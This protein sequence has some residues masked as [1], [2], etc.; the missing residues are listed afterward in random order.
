[1]K[2]NNFSFKK[3]VADNN[4]SCNQEI[5]K[6]IHSNPL[7]LSI[8][9][10]ARIA[11]IANSLQEDTAAYYTDPKTVDILCENLPTIKVSYLRI[12]EPSVGV[13]NILRQ[14]ITYYKD[15]VDIIE[16]DVFDINEH[17][18]EICKILIEKEFSDLTKI[19]INY[20]HADFLVYTFSKQYDL[21]VGNPPFIKIKGEYRQKLRKKFDNLVADNMSAF[22]LDK[23][24]ELSKNVVLIMPKYF[25]H[26]TDFAI[27]REKLKKIS[28]ECIV[29]FGESGFKGV[30][31]ETICLF[32]N[33]TLINTS[34]TKVISVPKHLKLL[35]IQSEITQ[36]SFP[37][38]LLYINKNFIDLASQLEFG[39]FKVF[40]DR[41]ITSKMLSS[42]SDIWV[43]R[44]KNIPRIGG[45]ANHTDNDVF[46][47][48]DQLLKLS[49]FKYLDRTDVFLSPNMTYYPRVIKK[50]KN[51]VV[52]GSIAIFELKNNKT[53]STEDLL[54]FSSQEF[55]DFYRVARNYS[56][57][58]LNIDNIAI[59]YFGKK[60]SICSTKKN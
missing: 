28:I 54:F 43:I 4:L 21:V 50:P 10:L 52:N 35:Q 44:S 5:K 22:F 12:L 27:S 3:I 59:F 18:L 13:G 38:W 1:L 30:L 39:I 46:I 29:D 25:L 51:C 55:E 48:K 19:K 33:T 32:I 14:I 36:S 47:K 31:I 26:N 17:S 49:V 6:F 41:Q 57:R 42:N 56:N 37:N 58:S 11:E 53:L 60:K 2:K 23:A 34:V 15:K 9:N 45:K 40:R 7:K 16:C 8:N 24:L 20:I